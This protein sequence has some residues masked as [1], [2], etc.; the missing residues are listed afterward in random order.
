M[1]TAEAGRQL[2]VRVRQV[3]RLASTG[4]LTQVGAVGRTML[5]DARSV[6]RVTAQGLRRGRLWSAKAIAAT[7]DLLAHQE[8]TR[9]SSAERKRPTARLANPSAEDLVRATRSR[10][11]VRR[12]RSSESFVDRVREQVSLTGAAAIDRDT[13]P[14]M[15]FGL[16]PSTNRKRSR[17]T[18]TSDSSS[19][20]HDLSVLRG[21]VPHPR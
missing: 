3:Q 11:V 12:Y 17:Y 18:K 5:I 7:L 15:E 10:A 14:A 6:R 8:T 2:G 16:S 19:Q 20:K 21:S 4:L 1:S 9:L 13:S